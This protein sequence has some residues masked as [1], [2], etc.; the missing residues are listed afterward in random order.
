[1]LNDGSLLVKPLLTPIQPASVDL[2]LGYE[3]IVPQGGHIIDPMMG[4][5]TTDQPKAFDLHYLKPGE[6]VNVCTLEYVKIP[7]NLAGIVVG[8]ST[9]ARFGLQVESAGF[10]DPGWEGRLTLELKN[11]GPDTIVLR[12]TMKI[13][14]IRFEAMNS[15]PSLLYGDPDLGSHYQGADG[16]QVGSVQTLGA[17]RST[18]APEHHSPQPK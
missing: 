3:I 13:C 16:P 11:L 7:G 1:M 10:V 6:F 2:R 9:L 15:Q 18:S 14:Q 5:G 4:L 8:K 12:P 17:E